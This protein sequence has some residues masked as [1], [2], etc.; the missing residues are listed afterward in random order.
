M[1][2]HPDAQARFQMLRKMVA[3]TESQETTWQPPPDNVDGESNR[4]DSNEVVDQP[5]VS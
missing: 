3:R 4:L 2:F 5:E 1:S